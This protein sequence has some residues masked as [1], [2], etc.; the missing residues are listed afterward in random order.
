MKKA[1]ICI[2]SLLLLVWVVFLQ[3]PAWAENSVIITPNIVTIS[4]TRGENESRTIVLRTDKPLSN[5]K[6]TALD[7]YNTEGNKVLP[8]SSLQ[9]NSSINQTDTNDLIKIP[10][11]FSF[12]NAPSGEFKGEIIINNQDNQ[13]V[14]P[15]IVKVKEPLYLPL[16]ILI[17][18]LGLGMTVSAYSS[19]GK[20]SDEIT[21]NLD[22]LRTQINSDEQEARTFYTRI[23]S[24][25]RIAQSAQNAKQFPDAEAEITKAR[26]TWRKWLEDR[27][28][29]LIQ[30]DYYD[31]LKERLNQD[32]LSSPCLYIQT[33]SRD[34]EDC[35]Q[36]S[37][38]LANATELNEKLDQLSQQL[39]LYL[40]LKIQLNKLRN[41]AILAEGEESYQWED[42]ADEFEQ[43]LNT[44]LPSNTNELKSLNDNIEKII[45]DLRKV[46]SET[47]QTLVAKDV[48]GS[49][50]PQ[51]NLMLQP[52]QVN[53]SRTSDLSGINLLTQI[54]SL[55]QT[56][57]GRLRLFYL[58]SYL[59]SFTVLAGSGF[60]ELYLSK[61]TF[62][63]NGWGDYLTL[64]AWG[65]GLK[66]L[67]IWRLK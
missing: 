46:L 23:D 25:L 18:G 37:P 67:V 17:F 42:Q 2:L 12:K 41:L 45:V 52:L 48:D 57:Q 40:K 33:I 9:I 59:I 58:S 44:L 26:E 13:W 54:A 21:V 43:I 10:L 61:P 35:L 50:Q 7:L 29:W 66:L 20:L 6:V 32:D 28:Y 38:D 47:P 49:S 16:L 36:R 65:F 3:F 30:F 27:P 11:N 34:L 5:I 31:Q 19:G 63:A 60:N 1:Q 56:A 55:W 24:Y 39:N 8:A 53:D 64:L 14:I 22:K 4:T 51:S 15:V 62:G